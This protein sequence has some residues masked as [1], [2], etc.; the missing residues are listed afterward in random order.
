M[1]VFINQTEINKEFLI[2]NDGLNYGRFFNHKTKDY[3]IQLSKENFI[4]LIEKEYIKVRDEIKIDDE[5]NNDYSDFMNTKYCS[6][7]ELLKY[8]TDFEEIFK[9]YLH[10]ILFK[11]IFKP[12]SKVK[13][14]INSTD[15]IQIM[16]D[17]VVFNGKVFELN[18]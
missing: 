9:T 14:V 10:L 18:N 1:K 4:D 12:S 15:S 17:K 5:I 7:Q 6:L 16:D 13:Y 11:K 3:K 2:V 8:Q